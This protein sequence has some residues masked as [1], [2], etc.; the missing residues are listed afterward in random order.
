MHF[1][2]NSSKDD[3]CR[4]SITFTSQDGNNLSDCHTYTNRALPQKQQNCLLA[5]QDSE[6]ERQDEALMLLEHA[7]K[8]LKSGLIGG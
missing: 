8:Q 4:T 5:P 6:D 7:Q 3:D 2:Y 1:S